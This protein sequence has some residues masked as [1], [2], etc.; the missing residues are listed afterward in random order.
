[1]QGGYV[2]IYDEQL[3]NAISL[4]EAKIKEVKQAIQSLKASIADQQIMLTSLRL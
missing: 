1:M 2:R 3:D 4:V